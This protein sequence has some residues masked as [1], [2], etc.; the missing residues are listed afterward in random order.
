MIQY[1]PNSK[2]KIIGEGSYLQPF[3]EKPISPFNQGKT[4]L[5]WK[6]PRTFSLLIRS[7]FLREVFPEESFGRFS[8]KAVLK[9]IQIEGQKALLILFPNK[10]KEINV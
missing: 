7:G 8:R 9:P 2:S 1:H 4:I 6:S 5:Y 3:E 10:E